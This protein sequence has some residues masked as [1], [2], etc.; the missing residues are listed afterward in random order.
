MATSVIKRNSGLVRCGCRDRES[1]E[2][3]VILPIGEIRAM[4]LAVG[5]ARDLRN[6]FFADTCLVKNAANYPRSESF[7]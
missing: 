2:T 3:H 5:Q 7:L 4:L 1:A 6:T